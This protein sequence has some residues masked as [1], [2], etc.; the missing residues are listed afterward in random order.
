MAILLLNSNDIT[1][2]EKNIGINKDR[3]VNTSVNKENKP[4]SIQVSSEE[5]ILTKREL[6][7]ELDKERKANKYLNDL[8]DRLVEGK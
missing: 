8:I 5:I 3:H 4:N 6:E 2:S 7:K 1:V